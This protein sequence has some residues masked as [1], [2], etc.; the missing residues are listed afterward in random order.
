MKTTEKSIDCRRPKTVNL[1]V[2]LQIPSSIED[3]VPIA[4]SPKTI[5]LFKELVERQALVFLFSILSAPVRV[6][7]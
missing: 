5:L 1:F 2:F 3:L 4:Q 6:S 7:V